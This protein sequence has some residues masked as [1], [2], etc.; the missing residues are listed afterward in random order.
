MYHLEGGVYHLCTTCV[1]GVPQEKVRV[2]SSSTDVYHVYHLFRANVLSDIIMCLEMFFKR[3]LKKVVHMVQ[4]VHILSSPVVAR[5]WCV[6]LSRSVPGT[7]LG[8]VVHTLP[9]REPE[10]VSRVS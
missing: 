5:L 10:T 2:Y 7:H 4:V 8:L 9:G 6:P 3:N 1:P